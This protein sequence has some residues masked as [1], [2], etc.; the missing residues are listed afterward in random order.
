MKPQ[1]LLAAAPRGDPCVTDFSVLPGAGHLSAIL[2]AEDDECLRYLICTFLAR[3][4]YAVAGV[5]DGL[6]AWEALRQKHYDLLVSDNEMPRLTGLKLVARI[7]EAR[8]D[9]PIIMATGSCGAEDSCDYSH[10]EI[11]SWILKPFNVVD[12]LP[13]VGTVLRGETAAANCVASHPTHASPQS[14]G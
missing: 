8:M 14:G 9:L 4:G 5:A 12:L 2:V 11:S 3:A 13:L 7:R 1:T 10:L 6:H